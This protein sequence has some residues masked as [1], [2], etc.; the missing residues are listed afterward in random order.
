MKKALFIFLSMM[1]LPSAHADTYDFPYLAF[2]QNNGTVQTVAVQSL[3]LTFSNGTLIATNSDGSKSFILADLQKM[4]FTTSTEASGI[5]DVETPTDSPVEIFTVS[6]IAVGKY[7]TL[8]AA[9]DALAKGIYIAKQ[10][11]GSTFKIA[12]K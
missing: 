2:K 11:N 3:V 6:G 8:A 1:G 7:D 4:Y 10:Q 9:K 12:V 5:T